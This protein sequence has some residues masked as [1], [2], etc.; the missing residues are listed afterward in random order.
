M[1]VHGRQAFAAPRASWAAEVGFVAFRRVGRKQHDREH[2]ARQGRS[3][4]CG[5]EKRSDLPGQP[6]GLRGL[7]L[8]ALWLRQEPR[9]HDS[10]LAQVRLPGPDDGDRRIRQ[11]R[12]AGR[13]GRARTADV[14]GPSDADAADPQGQG[15]L[16][17]ARRAARH[18]FRTPRRAALPGLDAGDRGRA[19][20][21]QRRT[22][23]RTLWRFRGAREAG[24]QGRHACR[25][26]HSRAARPL[27]DPYH[28]ALSP[29]LLQRGHRRRADQRAGPGVDLLHHERLRPRG[30]EPGLHHALVAGDRRGDRDGV[31]GYLASY[32]RP[33][34]RRGRQE[35]GPGD[36][37]HVVPQGLV[38]P[39]GAS[40]AV[41]R[42]VREP[43][44]RV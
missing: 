24:R 22:A 15:R 11:R 13:D 5:T 23:R 17:P 31:R 12:H 44:A 27:A 7:A 9:C 3:T 26:A 32:A 16:R 41:L 29:L 35:G 42:L 4:G 14:A 18:G 2:L 30:A 25:R 39:H 19:C 6:A 36:G 37:Q 8:R 43:T 40:A 10:R 1:R 20:R 21:V 28:L 33:P 34:D 38:D